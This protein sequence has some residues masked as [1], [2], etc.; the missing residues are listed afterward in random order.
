MSTSSPGSTM[1]KHLPATTTWQRICLVVTLNSVSLTSALPKK[2]ILPSLIDSGMLGRCHKSGRNTSLNSSSHCGSHFLM[3][4]CEHGQTST[5]VLVWVSALGS[6]RIRAM[7]T[8]QFAVGCLNLCLVRRL[9]R[10]RIGQCNLGNL[11]LRSNWGRQQ[12]C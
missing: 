2:N 8:T 1:K 5:H 4:P 3:S 11:S 12:G 9:L 10:E 6:P 7:S